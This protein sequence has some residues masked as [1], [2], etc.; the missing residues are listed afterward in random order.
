MAV[1]EEARQLNVRVSAALHRAVSFQ[2][3]DE[4][5]GLTDLVSRALVEYLERRTAEGSDARRSL[6]ASDEAAAMS[7][8]A[9]R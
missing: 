5:V 9:E 1:A 3:Y 6:M 2:A 4:R 8:A 7:A